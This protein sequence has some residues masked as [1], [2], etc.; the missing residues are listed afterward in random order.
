MFLYFFVFQAKQRHIE[1]A[2]DGPVGENNTKYTACF[3]FSIKRNNKATLTN[4]IE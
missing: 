2:D 3:N 4:N 1:A